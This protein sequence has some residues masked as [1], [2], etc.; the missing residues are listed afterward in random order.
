MIDF[1]LNSLQK[2]N[3]SVSLAFKGYPHELMSAIHNRQCPS[4]LIKPLGYLM[5]FQWN[6]MEFQWDPLDFPNQIQ[7]NPMNIPWTSNE[8]LMKINGIQWNSME[9]AN[10]IQSVVYPGGKSRK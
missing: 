10:Q 5:F 4:L 2:K 6:S 8:N 7:S 3:T 1:L 9:F